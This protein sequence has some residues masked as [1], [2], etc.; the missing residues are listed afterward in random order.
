ME[1][2]LPEAPWAA[3]RHVKPK[4]LPQAIGH[5]GYSAAFPENTMAAFRGAIEVGATALEANLHL[6]RDGVVVISHVSYPSSDCSWDDL[7]TLRTLRE[8]SQPM[9]RFVD[10]LG[11]LNEPVAEHVWL[12]LDIKTDDDTGELL[13]AIAAAIA[14][15]PT[16]KRPWT[17]RIMLGP[18]D[19]DWFAKCLRLVPGFPVALI[20]FSPDYASA[21]L[22][23]PNLNFNLYNYS[24]ATSRGSR[25]IVSAKENHRLVFSWSDNSDE[26]MS[27][28]IRNHA[29]GV[30]T[31]DP[32]RFKELCTQWD[33]KEVRERAS[34][35]T[36]KG[37]ILWIIINALVI[38][39]EV[40]AYCIRGSPRSRVAKS[41]GI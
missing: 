25:F 22:P 18:W 1:Y 19:A 36:L 12:L 33:V 39:G 14:S 4:R 23:V 3:A 16:S 5:R 37:T 2:T 40:V 32:L 9:P 24:F 7:S 10:F 28:S 11:Y 35:S 17:E 31:D 20:A 41:I 34:Q 27:L 21:M 6:S 30:I 8:P 26:L 29:D 38:L 13:T 15:V